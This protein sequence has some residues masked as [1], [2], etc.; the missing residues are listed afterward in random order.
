[1]DLQGRDGRRLRQGDPDFSDVGPVTI[2]A[3][4]VARTAEYD[5]VGGAPK[6]EPTAEPTPTDTETESTDSE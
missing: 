2:E 3:P 6:T 5:K 4:V 1:M